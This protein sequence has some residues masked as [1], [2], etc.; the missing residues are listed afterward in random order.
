[1]GSE[2]MWTDIRR[3]VEFGFQ[4][5]MH[6]MAQARNEVGIEAIGSRQRHS[7]LRLS[8]ERRVAVNF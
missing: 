6:G 7:A 5:K 2:S 1:M 4:T 3:L 8:D